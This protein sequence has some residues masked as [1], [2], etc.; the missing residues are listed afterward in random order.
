MSGNYQELVDGIPTHDMDTFLGIVR[1]VAGKEAGDDA[2]AR[3]QMQL[4][5]L[6]TF[7]TRSAAAQLGVSHSTV[8]RWRAEMG[9]VKMTGKDGKVRMNHQ[10]ADLQNARNALILRLRA[11]GRSVRNIASEARCSVG[12]VHRVIKTMRLA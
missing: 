12:T 11:E 10:N 7:S 4:A 8:A 1:K 2:E 3:M 6:Q 9:L 5:I